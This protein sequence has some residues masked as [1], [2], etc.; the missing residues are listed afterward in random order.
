MVSPAVQV[1]ADEGCVHV[2][3][4][5]VITTATGERRSYSSELEEAVA[6]AV[7]VVPQT[8]TSRRCFLPMGFNQVVSAVTIS[9]AII[10]CISVNK[11]WRAL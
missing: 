9:T 10:L 6:V 3:P 11:S 5:V 1:A 2:L 8:A 4:L 7:A